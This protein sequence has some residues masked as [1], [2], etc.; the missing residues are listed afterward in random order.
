[1]NIISIQFLRCKQLLNQTQH[2]NTVDK[3]NNKCDPASTVHLKLLWY[4]ISFVVIFGK[5]I[6]GKKC[7]NIIK[8]Y[9]MSKRHTNILKE[10]LFVDHWF[11]WT[12]QN[13]LLAKQTFHVIIRLHNRPFATVII[14]KTRFFHNAYS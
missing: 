13:K 10:P 5:D 3:E 14:W 7:A 2:D 8:F 4:F 6:R 11:S 9:F 1:M 12:F